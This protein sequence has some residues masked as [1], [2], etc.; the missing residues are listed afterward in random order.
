MRKKSREIRTYHC[1][2]ENHISA[3]EHVSR[4]GEMV[5]I[6]HVWYTL[7]SFLEVANLGSINDS[8]RQEMQFKAATYSLKMISKFDDRRTPEHSVLTEDRPAML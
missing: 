4:H 2:A 7:K 8:K 6:D 3:K 5:Q 1:A